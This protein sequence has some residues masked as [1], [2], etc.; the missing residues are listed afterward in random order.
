[1]NQKILFLFEL[2]PESLKTSQNTIHSKQITHT[3]PTQFTD[4]KLDLSLPLDF[5][6]DGVVSLSNPSKG[7]GSYRGKETGSVKWH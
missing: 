3:H 1:M 2:E 5:A 6:R 7:S 4:I